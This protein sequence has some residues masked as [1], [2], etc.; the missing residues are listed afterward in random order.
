[1]RIE[2]HSKSDAFGRCTFSLIWMADYHPG[3]PEG[4]YRRAERGQVFFADPRKH[5]FPGPKTRSRY[6]GRKRNAN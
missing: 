3:H 4:E 1:M 2:Y 5:G 6:L